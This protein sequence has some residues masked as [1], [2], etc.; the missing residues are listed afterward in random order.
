MDA[1]EGAGV[2]GGCFFERKT[3]WRVKPALTF[4]R[5][6]RPP[7]PRV[8][9]PPPPPTRSSHGAH[10]LQGQGD[11]VLGA[12]LQ[13]VAPVVAEDDRGGGGCLGWRLGGVCRPALP[14]S[15]G[16]HTVRAAPAA[17]GTRRGTR[18]QARG[19]PSGGP[20]GRRPATA[21]LHARPFPVRPCPVLSHRVHRVLAWGSDAGPRGTRDRPGAAR[22]AKGRRPTPGP[23]RAAPSLPPSS[24]LLPAARGRAR[25]EPYTLGDR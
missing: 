12:A 9:P 2:G 6:F 19:W 11:V 22:P 25:S 15:G 4:R 10:A 7:P 20:P 21:P 17:A 5:P 16:G 13:A 8:Y 18:W 24:P 14:A 3:R 1:R 23:D